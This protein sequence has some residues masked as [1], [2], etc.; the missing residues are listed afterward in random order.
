MEDDKSF[1]PLNLLLCSQLINTYNTTILGKMDLHMQEALL[2]EAQNKA[3]ICAMTNKQKENNQ[4]NNQPTN[5]VTKKLNFVACQV[6]N[7]ILLF[8]SVFGT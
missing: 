3:E 8:F 1:E 5:H 2:N 6:T 4:A 7:D